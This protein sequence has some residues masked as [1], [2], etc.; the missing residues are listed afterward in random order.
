MKSKILKKF[1]NDIDPPLVKNSKGLYIILK[2]NKKYLDTTSGWTSYATLGLSNNKIINSMVKQ[3]KKFAHVDFNVW[4]NEKIE[5]LANRLLKYANNGID[6]IYFGGTSGSD[7]IEAAMKLSYQIHHDSG[8]KNKISFISR[9]Q[10]FNGATLHAMSV[11]DLPILNLYNPLLPKNIFKISQHNQYKKCFFDIKKNNCKCKKSYKSCMGKMIHEN[12]Q[13]YTDR[14]VNELEEKILEIGP[15]NVAAFVGETQ[16]GSLVGDVPPSKNYWKKISKVCRKYNIHLIL[17]EV[18]C[19]MGRS[20]KM[21][22]YTWDN[23]SPD[24]VCMG[25]NM[26]SGH[27]PLS[28][29]LTKSK[30]EKIIAKGSG[31]IQLGHTFQGFSTGIAAC[32]ELINIMEEKKLLKRIT[33]KGQYMMKILN[34][35]LSDERYFGNVR[36]RGYGFSVEHNTKNNHMFALNLQQVMRDKYK[37]IIN[38]KWHRTSFVPS[39][40]IS[41]KQIDL[42]ISTFVDTFKS[43]SKKLNFDNNLRKNKISKSMGGIK[44]GK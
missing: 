4:K 21:L 38:S 32:L 30:F 19:G 11:S 8:N 1:P 12:N 37:I 9:H 2:N 14:C 26:T 29:I 36:G 40:L 41:D 31:R 33:N 35:E 42:L 28:A 13:S 10:S 7:A 3:M 6:R 34:E 20:G 43:L 24:F 44:I 15:K 22:N 17:D 23:F 16:L 18:Y 27:A 25:K 5:I 39:F